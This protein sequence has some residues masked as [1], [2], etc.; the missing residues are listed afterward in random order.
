[1]KLKRIR[2]SLDEGNPCLGFGT[3]EATWFGVRGC[4]YY[5][6]VMID[7]SLGGDGA[8]D[9]GISS[10]STTVGPIIC[11]NVLGFRPMRLVREMK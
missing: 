7:Y 9:H 2:L 10:F 8:L 1:M 5:G 4:S 3:G 6:S 11:D